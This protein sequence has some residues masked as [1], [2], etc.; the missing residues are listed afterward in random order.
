MNLSSR[1]TAIIVSLSL[2]GFAAFYFMTESENSWQ[3]GRYVLAFLSFF[4]NLYIIYLHSTHPPHPKFL[5]LRKR[6]VSIRLH[7]ISGSIEFFAAIAAF[8]MADPTIPAI[9]MAVAAVVHI[10][11]SFFQTP[12]VF[13]AKAVMIPS[14][15]GATSLHLFCAVNLL[16]NPTSPEWLLNTYLAL[17]IYAW[18]RIYYFMFEKFGL[19]ENHIYSFSVLA[20]GFTIIPAILGPAGNLVVIGYVVLY[21]LLYK[22]LYP[23]DT[24]GYNMQE[25]A[26]LSLIDEEAR[27]LWET[28]TLGEQAEQTF[29]S[30]VSR[31]LAE[32]VYAALDK[33]ESGCLGKAEVRKM[34]LS[35]KTPESF[36]DAVMTKIAGEDKALTFDEFYHSVWSIGRVRDRLMAGT[37][38][39]ADFKMTSDPAEQARFIFDYLD[40]DQNG[41]LDLFELEMLLLEWGLPESEIR[42]YL[43][44]FDD[45]D[46]ER[47]SPEEFQKHFRPVWKFGY[48]QVLHLSK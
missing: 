1:M 36:I 25:S 44:M 4:A 13:G 8:F 34:L 14:Y 38:T 24:V 48:D 10:A 7:V 17:N 23:E 16:I 3:M 35:W 21:I 31:D 37:N 12:I 6:K 18:V 29:E 45:N 39:E 32:R 40:L 28:E 20:A 9:I 22:A 41:F 47:I 27:E 33:D 5:L 15:L 46:D 11:T 42:D 2:L 19:F 43:T 26:R 30:R